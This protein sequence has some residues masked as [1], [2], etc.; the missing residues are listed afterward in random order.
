MGLGPARTES[1]SSKFSCSVH[2][3]AA[4]RAGRLPARARCVLRAA[5]SKSVTLF[6]PQVCRISRSCQGAAEHSS[7]VGLIEEMV[8]SMPERLKA[9]VDGE[10]GP[11]RY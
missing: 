3:L 1:T 5:P 11:T 6:V 10:G 8:D 2:D 7:L 4:S 9:L